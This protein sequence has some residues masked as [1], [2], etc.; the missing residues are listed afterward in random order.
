M[1]FTANEALAKLKDKGYKHTDKREFLIDLFARKNCYLTARDVL[2]NM[3][4]DFKGISFDTIY[5]NLSLF[6]ELGIFEETDLSGE[7]NFRLAC[8]HDHH[9]H[10]FICLSCG[11]TREIMMC[12]MDFLTEALPGYEIDG[13]KF[14]VYGKCPD[15]QKAK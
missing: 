10:H 1:V 14:E 13:H 11:R 4:D 7:K 9:H 6:V 12:P 3:K 5:R 2:D 15:C 8:S